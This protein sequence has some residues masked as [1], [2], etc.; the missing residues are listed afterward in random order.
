MDGMEKL[1]KTQKNNK[2]LKEKFDY[3]VDKRAS[4]PLTIS[5]KFERVILWYIYLLAK[6]YSGSAL[7]ECR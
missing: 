2:L 5:K 1:N 4:N 3:L 7:G 6:L